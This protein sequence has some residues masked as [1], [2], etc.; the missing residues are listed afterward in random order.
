MKQGIPCPSLK[1][2]DEGDLSYQKK[3]IASISLYI[4][5]HCCINCTNLCL[6]HPVNVY[7]YKSCV[8][9]YGTDE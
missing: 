5:S 6:F 3:L 4:V 2:L 8:D 9:P 1:L 7:A